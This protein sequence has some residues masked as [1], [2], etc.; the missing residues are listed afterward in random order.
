MGSSSLRQLR[1]VALPRLRLSG[2][3]SKALSRLD[4]KSSLIF[5]YLE[6]DTSN[7]GG[8]RMPKSPAQIRQKIRQAQQKQRQAINKYNREA[9]RHNQKVKQAA[10]NYNRAVND[11]NRKVRAHNSRVKANRQRI[12]NELAKLSRQST[13]TRYTVYRT[14]VR[15][16]HSSYVRLDEHAETR[17][18]NPA[19]DRLVD[20]SER[21]VANSLSVT[22]ALLGDESNEEV[23]DTLEDAAL[24]E[25][26]R[27]ISP[28][29][30]DRW[31]GAVYSL[32][33]LNPDAARH[34]CTSAREI[35]TEILE[36]KEVGQPS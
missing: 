16:L 19:Y 5:L 25:E 21:E 14:S 36:V 22:N 13:T 29:L 18:S 4:S 1:S 24:T 8:F 10:N 9:R 6:T 11:Y 3:R 30:D 35:I 33:P 15:T 34:F 2:S 7:S 27:K 26:L 31:R 20:F 32:S 12:K 28:E 17:E 23:P